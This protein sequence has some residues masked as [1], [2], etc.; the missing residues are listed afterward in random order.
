MIK[1]YVGEWENNFKNGFGKIC[2]GSANNYE[3]Q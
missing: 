1:K 3:G 2:N